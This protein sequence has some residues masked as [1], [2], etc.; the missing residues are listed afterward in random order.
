M[1][2]YRIFYKDEVAL[3]H[4]NK[5]LSTEIVFGSMSETSEGS[6]EIVLKDYP[7]STFYAVP[8]VS[9][10]EAMREANAQ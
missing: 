10:S 2:R 8:E 1:K 7:Q 5:T 4:L 9:S 3:T 6:F